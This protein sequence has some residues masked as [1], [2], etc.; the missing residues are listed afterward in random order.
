MVA[1][2]GSFK[3]KII[4]SV[5]KDNLTFS[6]LILIPFISFSYF[7]ALARNSSTILRISTGIR[8]GRVDIFVL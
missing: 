6:F 3:Y 7:T 5:N 1:F 4:S 8:V 2:S